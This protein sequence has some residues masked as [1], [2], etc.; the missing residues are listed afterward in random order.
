MISVEHAIE[1]ANS[2]V[3]G[4]RDFV[5]QNNLGD[6]TPAQILYLALVMCHRLTSVSY[7]QSSELEIISHGIELSIKVLDDMVEVYET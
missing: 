6:G 3:E 2:L 7:N 1:Q 5:A 4:L